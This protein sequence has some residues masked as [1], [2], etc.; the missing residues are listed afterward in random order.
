MA[1]VVPHHSLDQQELV[2]VAVKVL[3]LVPL[4]EVE[5]MEVLV[6]VVVEK[7]HQRT[8]QE[9]EIEKLKLQIPQH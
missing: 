2:G 4:G 5:Q 7:M 6:V 1:Q 3:R 9:L 8:Q